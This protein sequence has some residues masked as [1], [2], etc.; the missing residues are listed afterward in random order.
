MEE[1]ITSVLELDDSFSQEKL[2]NIYP[3]PVSVNEDLF[4]VN[5]YPDTYQFSIVDRYGRTVTSSLILPG[6]NT[7][8]V[9]NLVAGVY[10]CIS[11]KGS[12]RET[13]KLVI[14]K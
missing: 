8:S 3:N 13:Y 4:I 11:E 14:Q 12:Y 9:N 2:L 5:D 1:N 7:I 6:I 10:F